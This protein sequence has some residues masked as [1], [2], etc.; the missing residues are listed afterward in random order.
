MLGATFNL[1]TRVGLSYFLEHWK[2][3]AFE[4]KLKYQTIVKSQKR[5]PKWRQHFFKNG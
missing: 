2:M 1:V 3:V 5:L 4:L